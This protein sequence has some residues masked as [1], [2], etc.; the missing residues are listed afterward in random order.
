MPEEIIEQAPKNDWFKGPNGTVYK[1]D[2]KYQRSQ[3]P[4]PEGEDEKYIPISIKPDL[5]HVK[6]D[7][8][9]DTW[10]EDTGSKQQA[11]DSFVNSSMKTFMKAFYDHLDELPIG[12]QTMLQQWKWDIDTFKNSI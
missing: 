1:G 9:T 7:P 5:D 4:T 8:D 6:Y 10:I 12:V 2:I 3:D 11:I